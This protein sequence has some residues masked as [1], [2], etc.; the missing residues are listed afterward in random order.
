[1]RGAD[2]YRLLGVLESASR[3][4]IRRAYRA[5]AKHHHPDRNPGDESA[6]MRFKQLVAAYMVLR[7]AESRQRYDESRARGAAA[8][9]SRPA[10]PRPRPRR[11]PERIDDL[12][13][14]CPNPACRQKLRIVREARGQPIRCPICGARFDPEQGAG[15]S[16]ARR[17]PAARRRRS[18]PLCAFEMGSTPVVVTE[19]WVQVGT[20]TMDVAAITGIRCGVSLATAALLPAGRSY[21]VWLTDGRKELHIDCARG[22][23]V[24][25]K[26]LE[27]RYGRLLGALRRTVM[28]RIVSRMARSLGEGWGSQVG[29]VFFDGYGLHRFGAMGGARRALFGVWSSLFGGPSVEE[30]ALHATHLAW[31]DL[32][33]YKQVDR[34]LILYDRARNKWAE[35]DVLEDWNAVCLP[36]LIDALGEL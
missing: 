29:E 6:E 7:D 12:I 25:R 5:L 23:R 24:G 27:E 8:W 35:L 17:A 1:M 15:P 31:E 10:P 14:A 18:P 2:Y 20:A 3:E 11:A 16:A 13:A 26:A 28:V 33:A 22:P 4:Q 30:I 19:R 9:Q 32:G 34:R 36:A 21:A